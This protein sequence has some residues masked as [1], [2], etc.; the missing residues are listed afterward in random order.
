MKKVDSI[1]PK[2]KLSYLITVSKAHIVPAEMLLFTLTKKTSNPIVVVGNLNES[3]IS[4]IVSYGVK[5]ID[6]NDINMSGRLPQVKWQEKYRGF[7]WYKQM[8]IRLSID[9]FMSS[10]QVVILDSEVFVFDNWDEAR[11]YDSKTGSPRMLYWIPKNRKPNWDYKMYKGAAY[12]LSFLPECEGIMEYADSNNYHRHI[13]GVVLF[14]TK[15]VAKL[16][17]R[18]SEATDLNRNITVLFND[19]KDLAFSDHDLYGLAVEYGVFDSVVPTEQFDNL[20]GW[21]D[22]HDDPVFNK[23]K[24]GAMWSMC[25]NHS[26]YPNIKQY[27][28]YMQKAAQKLK[29]SLPETRAYWNKEDLPLINNKIGNLDNIEYFFKYSRQLDY[30]FRRRFITMLTSLRYIYENT[31]NPVIV[32]VGT[33]RDSTKGGGHSTYKFAEYC[34]KFGGELHT[35]DISKDAL[36]FS[37]KAT[38]EYMPWISY[39]NQDSSIFI[40]NF[41]KK[42]DFLYLDG[43]DSTPGKEKEASRVQLQEIKRAIPKLSE[44][45][46]VLL[47]D[48]DLPGGGKTGL[49]SKY[50]M[51]HGFKLVIND[52]QQLYIRNNTKPINSRRLF[53]AK[54]R[55]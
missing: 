52:Y 40:E 27:Y 41:N 32:E 30:T 10:D 2:S 53:R 22:N 7:G 4:K 28:G 11:L 46:V 34:A 45:C 35:V 39:H 54:S 1:V 47:D 25:Q 12:L 17:E 31:N 49:S 19:K 6:E 13:S 9:R 44:K 29:V 55:A 48:A 8:F 3:Q 23:F 38:K 50:L 16:W 26:S 24:D 18:L 20:L 14:S 36:E 42:I 5:Y 51:N 21:Y 15:N 43:F 37:K 33:L